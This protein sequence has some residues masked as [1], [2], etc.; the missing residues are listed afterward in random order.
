MKMSLHKKLSFIKSAIRIAGY[1]AIWVAFPDNPM[2]FFAGVILVIS[3]VIGI[4]EE[5][6]E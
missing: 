6:D 2:A 3:E 4:I 1:F 5:I